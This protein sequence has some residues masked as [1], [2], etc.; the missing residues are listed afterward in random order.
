MKKI[1]ILLLLFFLTSCSITTNSNDSETNVYYNLYYLQTGAPYPYID[2]LEPS[3][4][5]I[6]NDLTF[7]NKTNILFVSPKLRPNDPTSDIGDSVIAFVNSEVLVYY[8][9]INL[10]YYALQDN[11]LKKEIDAFNKGN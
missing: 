10:Q 8:N 7:L 11:S 3:V 4:N 2:P 9:K 5:V 1:L 6:Q